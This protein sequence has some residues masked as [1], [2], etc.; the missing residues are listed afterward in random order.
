MDN[1]TVFIL[2]LMAAITIIGMVIGSLDAEA[3]IICTQDARGVQYCRDT[4]TGQS[5][6]INPSPVGSSIR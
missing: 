2:K 5:W 4:V 3:S 1:R 6:T